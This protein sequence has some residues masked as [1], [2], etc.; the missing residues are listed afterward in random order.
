MKSY[1]R[2]STAEPKTRKEAVK[3]LRILLDN[4]VP[5]KMALLQVSKQ[6]KKMRLPHSNRTIYRWAAEF[7]VKTN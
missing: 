7:H 5:R 4:H 1:I 3:T 6:L 2:V